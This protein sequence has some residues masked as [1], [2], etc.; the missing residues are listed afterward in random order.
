MQ[1][2]S[3]PTAAPITPANVRQLAELG[4]TPLSSSLVD[5]AWS[6]NDRL[7]AVSD[8]GQLR[9]VEAPALAPVGLPHEIE[10]RALAFSPDGAYLATTGDEGLRLWGLGVGVP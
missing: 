7:L 1:T 5:L 10:A 6:P 8:L 9:L 3:Q 4:R 2:P